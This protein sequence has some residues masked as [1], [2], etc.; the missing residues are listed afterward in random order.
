VL[1]TFSLIPPPHRASTSRGSLSLPPSAHRSL[2]A[3]SPLTPAV[4]LRI[5]FRQRDRPAVPVQVPQPG[6]RLPMSR[7]HLAST[8]GFVFADAL[9]LQ[10]RWR[11]G[12]HTCRRL[13]H[14]GTSPRVASPCSSSLVS[15]PLC[16]VVS[17]RRNSRLLA[18]CLPPLPPLAPRLPHSHPPRLWRA[19]QPQAPRHAPV[20][21]RARRRGVPRR[22]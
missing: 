18:P 16:R 10:C 20:P 13:S 5:S 22:V 9:R 14:V 15:P 2:A 8:S 21:P 1:S 19:H 17:H 12:L 6:E 4:P 7:L 11:M 3:R